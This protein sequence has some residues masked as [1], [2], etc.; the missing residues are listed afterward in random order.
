MSARLTPSQRAD[1]RALARLTRHRGDRVVLAP[2]R[3]ASGLHHGVVTRCWRWMR[4]AVLVP[5]GGWLCPGH[6]SRMEV[7]LD[8]GPLVTLD[9]RDPSRPW[10]IVEY[11]RPKRAKGGER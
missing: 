4:A 10:R 1:A 7:R 2:I 8:S 5:G 3:T 6:A 9:V 11:T